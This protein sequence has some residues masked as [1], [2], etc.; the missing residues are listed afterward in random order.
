MLIAGA[1]AQGWARMWSE[2]VGTAIAAHDGMISIVL[3][4]DPTQKPAPVYAITDA[5]GGWS[6]YYLGVLCPTGVIASP[7]WEEAMKQDH[8]HPDAIE[9]ARAWLLARAL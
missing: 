7:H 1:V 8:N 4:G 2:C 5:A 3:G 9:Q 6:I